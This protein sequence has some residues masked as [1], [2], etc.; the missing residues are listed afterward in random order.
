MCACDAAFTC[1]RCRGT[2]FDPHYVDD[3]PPARDEELDAE[4]NRHTNE[5]VLPSLERR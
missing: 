3:E 2:R 4:R 5:N 1:S